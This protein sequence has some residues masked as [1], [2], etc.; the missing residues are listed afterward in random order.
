[1]PTSHLEVPGGRLLVV[2]EGTGPPIVLLH[3]AVADLRA[4]DAMVPP[5]VAA[6]YRV[7]RFDA[8]NFGGSTG[9][10]VAFTNRADVIAVLDSL[11]LERA[12]LVGN[13][14]GGMTAV[15]TAIESPER[16]VAVVGVGAGIG[17]FEGVPKPEELP[18]F[19]AY[20]AVDSADPFDVD[21]LTEFE[22]NVWLDGPFQPVG[23]VDRA[24][25]DAFLAMA[26]PLNARRP[27]AGS[28]GPARA[29]G[30]R[31]TRRASL[32]GPLRGRGARL[33]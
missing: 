6:G 3:A 21:A 19:T 20:E 27:S 31:T 14:R 15:D 17:G 12:A 5:L 33:Q 30:E 10:D 23:R 2:D 32:P 4:W 7:V 1:M 9:D 16:V 28:R 26:G 25:R 8:R 13:S 24:I 18:V 22:A 11:G 29:G